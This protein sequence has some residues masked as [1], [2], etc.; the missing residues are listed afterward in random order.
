MVPIQ[1]I[2][3]LRGIDP[4]RPKLEPKTTIYKLLVV[5]TV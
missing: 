3:R 2:R 1:P 5:P 4:M